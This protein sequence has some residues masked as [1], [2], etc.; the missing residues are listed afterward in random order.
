MTEKNPGR[1]NRWSEKTS[2]DFI[3][4]G[5]YFVPDRQ[6]QVR[7]INGLLAALEGQGHLLD[8][9]CGEGLLDEALLEANPGITILGLDGSTEMLRRARERMSRFEDRFSARRFDLASREWRRPKQVVHAVFSSLSIHHLSGPQK[10]ALF[11]DV[12]E[13]LAPDGTFIIADV[14]AQADEMG[15]RQAADALDE[16]VRR[17][18]LELDGNT[19]AFDYFRREGWNIFRHLDPEDIDKPS[20]LFD[21]L[22]WLEQAGFSGVDVHWMLAGHAIFSGRKPA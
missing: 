15:R 17:R 13:L 2:L 1:S 4:Y 7:V 11:A 14:V 22:K 18:S 3:Q 9:C 10:Q 21:Q 5:R 16:A 20:T 12:F 6:Y 8:L 19:G